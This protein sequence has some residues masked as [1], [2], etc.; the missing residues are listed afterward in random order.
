MMSRDTM[1]HPEAEAADGMHF[2]AHSTALGIYIT[3]WIAVQPESGSIMKDTALYEHLLGLKLPWS[4]ESVDLSL[5]ARRVAVEV[6]LKRGQVWAAPRITRGEFT[7]TVGANASGG[8]GYLPVLDD[9]QSARTPLKYSGGTV[10]TGC[11]MG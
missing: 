10:G 11:A 1:S 6:V 3:D 8:I 2:S 4:V 7:S 9:L 5:A